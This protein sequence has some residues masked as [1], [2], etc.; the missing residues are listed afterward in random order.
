MGYVQT[1]LSGLSRI[2]FENGDISDR[3]TGYVPPV[4]IENGDI[5]DRAT[6]YVPPVPIIGQTVTPIAPV[7]YWR[8]ESNVRR[9]IGY[10]EAQWAALG[11]VGREFFMRRGQ[12]RDFGSPM[13]VASRAAALARVLGQ[14]Y[15]TGFVPFVPVVSDVIPST[16]IPGGPTYGVDDSRRAGVTLD[17]IIGID[18]VK[19]QTPAEAAGVVMPGDA[20]L[21]TQNIMRYGLM[22]VAGWILWDAFLKPKKRSHRRSRR[23]VRPARG[24]KYPHGARKRH[25]RQGSQ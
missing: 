11:P 14:T 9:V 12:K 5:S 25:L 23:A 16:I 17:D 2:R 18:P 22:A 1:G 7:P 15:G 8:D 21:S 20:P 19:I 6:G 3:A 24:R 10:S 4:P 13:E